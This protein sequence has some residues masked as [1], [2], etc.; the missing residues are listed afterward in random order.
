MQR[1][2]RRDGLLLFNIRYW[3]SVLLSIVQLGSAVL[4]VRYD[5]RNLFRCVCVRSG[6]TLL[7]DTV[8]LIWNCPPITLWEQRAALSALREQG[9]NAPTQEAI[10][11]A[12]T[13]QRALVERA[14]SKT[15][16]A[17]RHSQRYK[18]AQSATM[19]TT[20]TSAGGVDYSQPVKP[21]DAEIWDH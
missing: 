21:S 19:G 6:W 14:T 20:A 2:L 10:F 1:K 15:K 3:D 5:P 11:K 16:A 7:L 17:R 4:L 12:V 9:D 13:A 8:S 18:D